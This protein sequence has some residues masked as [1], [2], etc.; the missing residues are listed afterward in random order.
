VVKVS[1]FDFQ[2]EPALIRGFRGLNAGKK[3][4]AGLPAV[5]P[6]SNNMSEIGF[7][8]CPH[9]YLCGKT[10]RLVHARLED[11]LFGA[12]G[13][14]NLVE[15]SDKECGLVWLDP[16]PLLEDL[17]KA[18]ASYYTHDEGQQAIRTGWLRGFYREVKLAHLSRALGYEFKSLGR[19]ARWFSR[20]LF[21]FPARRMD[22]EGDVM[23]L[24]AHSGG[25]LLDVGC[26]SGERLERFRSLGWTVSG[27]DFDEKVVGIAK[28]RGLDVRCGTIPGTWF[29]TG[30]FDAITLNH[31]V[32]HVPDPVA[33]FEECER[34]L[35][36]GGKVVIT[37]PNNLC[38]GRRLFGNDWRGLEPPRHLHVFSPSSMETTLRKSNFRMISVSTFDS[39]SIWRMSLILKFGLTGQ[40]SGIF[41]PLA[42]KMAAG[43][44]NFA[45]RIGLM[46][47]SSAGECIFCVARKNV[48]A[49]RAPGESGPAT[50]S[51][52]AR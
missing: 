45:E 12:P 28:E 49:T 34:I 41:R 3:K 51:F 43:I 17:P 7:A 29:P 9:C 5:P 48:A 33:L 31:V 22:I 40:S 21:F 35:K 23:F 47:D 16:M 1:A 8:P 50:D 15:C 38:W 11:R 44:L 13:A 10:G 24:P 25:K 6:I 14:W 39:A 18:Y 27:L 4:P 30:A 37:T 36:P 32:E 2:P 46:F 26:G 52:C 42:I 19:I 20:L